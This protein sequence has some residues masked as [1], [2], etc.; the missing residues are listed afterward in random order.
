MSLIQKNIINHIAEH[1][2]SI[3]GVGAG[4]SS[5]SF[6]Y[7]IGNH[8]SGIPEFVISGLLSESLQHVLN[9]LSQ[10]AIARGEPFADGE[11]VNLGGKLSVR[12]EDA[13]SIAKSFMTIQAT[14]FYGNEDYA[15]QQVVLPDAS[16]RFPEDAGCDEP[17][18]RQM[19]YILL[20]LRKAH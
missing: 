11:L 10:Q 18:S 16:G 14:E 9:E 2:R 1:G 7:T 4:P 5:A 19:D 8:L 17:F 6:M 20:A 12:I 3:M 13:P 15:L